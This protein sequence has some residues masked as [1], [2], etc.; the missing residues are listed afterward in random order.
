MLADLSL[1]IRGLLFKPRRP[2]ASP[3]SLGFLKPSR[4]PDNCRSSVEKKVE[5]PLPLRYK[6]LEDHD[7]QCTLWLRL[8]DRRCMDWMF[9]DLLRFGEGGQ[10]CERKRTRTMSSCDVVDAGGRRIKLCRV[11][12]DIFY[13]RRCSRRD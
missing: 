4:T 10:A 1:P 6:R 2:F 9:F 7:T 5:F 11:R 12:S 8:P 13:Q 3:E